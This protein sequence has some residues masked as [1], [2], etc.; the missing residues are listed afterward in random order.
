MRHFSVFN[1][2]G[3]VERWEEVHIVHSH[4]SSKKEANFA[5]FFRQTQTLTVV[6][7]HSVERSSTLSWNYNPCRYKCGRQ[8]A[9]LWLCIYFIWKFR[10]FV[11]KMHKIIQHISALSWSHRVCLWRTA[12][13]SDQNRKSNSWGVCVFLSTT[14]DWILQTLQKILFSFSN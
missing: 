7:A 5:F 2:C 9:Q 4:I 1:V 10:V 8:N 12:L 6:F 14:A 13:F 11:S 3:F